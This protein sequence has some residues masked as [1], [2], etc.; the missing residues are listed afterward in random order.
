MKSIESIDKTA[1]SIGVFVRLDQLRGLVYST[2]TTRPH[3]LAALR[4]ASWWIFNNGLYFEVFY[5]VVV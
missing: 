3:P 1:K 2:N 5:D 4:L